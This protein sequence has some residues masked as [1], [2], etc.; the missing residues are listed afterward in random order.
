MYIYIEREKSPQIIRYLK[1]TL[2]IIRALSRNLIN[3]QAI[4]RNYTLYRSEKY[5]SIFRKERKKG[6]GEEKNGSFKWKV[7]FHR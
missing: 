4:K 1:K 3:P 5:D 7:E 6:G 2:L